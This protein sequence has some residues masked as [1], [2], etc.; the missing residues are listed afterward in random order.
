MSQ[1]PELLMKV[2]APPKP[3]RTISYGGGVQSTAMLILAATGRIDAGV[4]LFANTG[5]DSEHPATLRYVREIAAPYADAHGIELVEIAHPTET[6]LQRALGL[7]RNFPLPMFG[8]GGMPMSRGCTSEFKIR[9]IDAELKRRGATRDNPADVMIGISVDEIQRA[10][11]NGGIDP[12]QPRQR[13]WYPLLDLGL[14]RTDCTHIIEAAGLPVPGK[15]ACFFCPFHSKEAWR[16]LRVETPE[17]FDKS[18]AI[19]M[20]Y[21]R[22][23]SDAGLRDQTLTRHGPLVEALDDQLTFDGFDECDSGV[24]FT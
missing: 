23:L 9:V 8:E 7:R 3:L 4:A 10:K 11:T 24:C 1:E 19:E 12:R 16:R 22:K 17:L 18:V 13:R 14:R 6:L 15:S 21:R 20:T 5:D 2:L